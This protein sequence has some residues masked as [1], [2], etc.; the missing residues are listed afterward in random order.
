MRGMHYGEHYTF[1]TWKLKHCDQ[2][3]ILFRPGLKT[4]AGRLA[5]SGLSGGLAIWIYNMSFEQGVNFKDP[6]SIVMFSIIVLLAVVTL[7]S[8]LASAWNRLRIRRDARGDLIVATWNLLPRSRTFFLD[9]F[10][11]IQYGA[12]EVRHYRRGGRTTAHYWQ[13][14]VRLTASA[15]GNAQLSF[16]PYRQKDRPGAQPKPPDQ[17]NTLIQWLQQASGFPVSGPHIIE[18]GAYQRTQRMENRQDDFSNLTNTVSV[19]QHQSHAFS[20]LEDMPLPG[21]MKTRTYER[22]VKRDSSGNEQVFES[23][24]PLPEDLMEKLQ[25]YAGGTDSQTFTYRENDGQER[26]YHSLDEMPPHV[27]AHFERY[28]PPE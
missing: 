7:L 11:G 21:N 10:T 13:W 5:I 24:E 15:P 3:E 22:V 14:Y 16:F 2:N 27:R 28:M 26:T 12:E 19:S 20:P 18:K 1:S 4:L 8:P 23:G 25:Q 17:V 6:E 9:E